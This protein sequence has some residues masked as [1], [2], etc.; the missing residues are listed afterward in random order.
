MAV[1]DL[2]SVQIAG[3]ERLRPE[4]EGQLILQHDRAR[5]QVKTVLAIHS[6]GE[7]RVIGEF[8]EHDFHKG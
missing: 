6:E 1:V 2:N 8:R 4:V 5:E 7:Q 3:W